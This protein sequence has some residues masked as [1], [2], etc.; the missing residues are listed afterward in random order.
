MLVRLLRLDHARPRN[1]NASL[2]KEVQAVAASASEAASAITA[3]TCTGLTGCHGST[4]AGIAQHAAAQVAW[5][6]HHLALQHV[7]KQVRATGVVQTQA[8]LVHPLISV[9]LSLARCSLVVEVMS[10][11]AL[12]KGSRTLLGH[13]PATAMRM[14]TSTAAP[15]C[16]L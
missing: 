9:S 11:A 13:V 12:A 1:S 14:P 3:A 2:Q 7:L 15:S 16:L 6:P 4:A 8:S 10:L 5:V